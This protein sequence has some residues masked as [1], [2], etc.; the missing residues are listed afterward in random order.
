MLY[1]AYG[2]LRHEILLPRVSEIASEMSCYLKEI[3][4]EKAQTSVDDGG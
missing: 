2:R 4:Y 1:Q 3:S